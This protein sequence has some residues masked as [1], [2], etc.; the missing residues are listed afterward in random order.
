MNAKV[1]E[2][3]AGVLDRFR[4][5]DIPEAMA[6][7]MFPPA[8][9]PSAKWSLLN[10]TVMFFS[11][12]ADA[13]GFRQ[14]QAAGR[15]IKKGS[16]AVYILVPFLKKVKNEAG[17]EDQALLGFGLRPVYRMED[18]E[19]QT[20]DYEQ[21]E[22]PAFP[23]LYRAKEWGISVKAVPGNY[24]FY[25]YYSPDRKEIAL[26]T[27]AEKTFFHELSHAAHE[28]VQ[29]KLKPGQD[30]LQ[31]IVAE[32]SA[33]VLCRMVGRQ[34]GDSFGNSYHYIDNYAQKLNLSP[35]AACVKVMAD[36]EKV[37]NLILEAEAPVS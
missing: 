26:A 15:R 31:E 27:P 13:R 22:L 34:P 21:L 11:G 20:L 8:N 1:K 36:V 24:R 4:S 10:R 35:L 28:R 17:G 30:P 2:V 14:W 25:G 29:A 16:K 5:G 12:T 18:T 32:L 7:A 19:G 9:V 33:Q 3:L 6:V 37:I 23:L